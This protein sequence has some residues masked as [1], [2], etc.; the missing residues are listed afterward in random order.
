MTGLPQSAHFRLT[1]PTTHCFARSL[2][3]DEDGDDCFFANVTVMTETASL[4]L[5][6]RRLLLDDN[7][8]IYD[9]FTTVRRRFAFLL[10]GLR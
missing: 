2:R 1:H 5:D 10:F 3:T 6:S 9:L 8:L 4:D 7:H